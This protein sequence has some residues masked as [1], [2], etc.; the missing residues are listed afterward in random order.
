MKPK[1]VKSPA[2]TQPKKVPQNVRP[3]NVNKWGREGEKMNPNLPPKQQQQQMA[4]PPQQ[5]SPFQHRGANGVQIPYPN[6]DP[7]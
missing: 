3:P 6:I 1:P 4:P 7:R 2:V 5:Q